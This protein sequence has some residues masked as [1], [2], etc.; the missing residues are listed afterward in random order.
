M[1]TVIAVAGL[2]KA[3]GP[4]VA[5]DDVSFEVR[6]GEIFGIVGP[7]GAGKTTTVDC[8]TGM[9]EPDRGAVRVLGFDPTRQGRRLRERIGI[10]LQAAALPDRIKV[11][12]AL[13]LYAS[14]YKQAADWRELLRQWGLEEKRDAAF[15]SLSGGQKQRL[16]IALALVNNPELVFLDELT[17]GLDPQARRAAWELVEAIRGRGATVVLVTHFMDEAEHLCDR[18]AII[19]HGRI[20]ALDTPQAL[21]GSLARRPSVHFSVTDGFDSNWLLGVPGVQRVTH[22]NANVTVYGEGPL[23][24]K[25]AGALANHDLAPPDLRAERATLEDV[26]LTLTGRQIRE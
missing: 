11:W 19:D 15:V 21:I 14:F 12:E 7:N 17:A 26:F 24:A 20:V 1:D 18:V 3:Y 25:V 6:S 13:D 22:D 9:R 23:M 4:I 8:L 10:Q 5:V 2:G 16:F